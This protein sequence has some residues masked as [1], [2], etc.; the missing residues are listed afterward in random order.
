MIAKAFKYK[1]GS[2][3]AQR[4]NQHLWKEERL[5]RSARL[6]LI[7]AIPLLQLD[8]SAYLDQCARR[9]LEPVDGM[10]GIARHE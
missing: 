9:Y 3:S 8:P 6:G 7:E 1:S 2:K 10:R 5:K 4:L